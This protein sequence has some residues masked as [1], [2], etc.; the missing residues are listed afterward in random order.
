MIVITQILTGMDRNIN[1]SFGQ[2]CKHRTNTS[3]KEA[4]SHFMNLPSLY[5]LKDFFSIC[6]FGASILAS[7]D[8]K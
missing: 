2:Y 1:D 5:L 8:F 7:S 4:H 6:S 3:S